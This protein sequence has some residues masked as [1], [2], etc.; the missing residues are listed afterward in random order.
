MI[1]LML[2][3]SVIFAL[4]REKPQLLADLLAVRDEVALLTTS[5]QEHED[6]RGS[7][8]A[9]ALKMKHVATSSFVLDESRLDD[10]LLG[11]SMSF[12]I[13][14]SSNV[15]HTRDALIT[16]AAANHQAKLVIRDEDAVRRL[17]RAAKSDPSLA[18]VEV[19]G[20][21]ELEAFIASLLAR[22]GRGGHDDD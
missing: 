17:R 22:N 18:L 8:A 4:D 10:A 1:R 11:N 19:W 14:R 15:S 21:P 7:A 6:E 16:E 9:A 20:I 12:E 5:V 3:S 2:D 13:L